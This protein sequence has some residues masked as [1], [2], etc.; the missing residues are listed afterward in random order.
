MS[1]MPE[2]VNCVP[3]EGFVISMSAAAFFSVYRVCISSR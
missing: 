2:H 3:A 1:V